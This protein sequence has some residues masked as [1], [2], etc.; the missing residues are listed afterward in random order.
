MRIALVSLCAILS[1]GF[2]FQERAKPRGD[3]PRRESPPASHPRAG[4]DAQQP[5]AAQPAPPP[6]SS[7]QAK[8]RGQAER[9]HPHAG[10]A[11][12]PHRRHL[13]PDPD[14]L[15][16][17]QQWYW[18]DWQYNWWRGPN[19]YAWFPYFY[20]PSWY[21]EFWLFGY[22][23]NPRDPI[24]DPFSERWFYWPYRNAPPL[25]CGE[26]WVPTHRTA[27]HDP[28]YGWRWRYHGWQLRYFC[29]D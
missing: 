12:D 28:R 2:L 24:W 3:Q 22:R 13:R 7:P 18:H 5:P 20:P 26:Y 19:D 4:G 15:W 9:R 21:Y 23:C 6:P 17:R 16:R 14:H 27:V 8:P 1:V 11:V 10:R 29:I 25:G